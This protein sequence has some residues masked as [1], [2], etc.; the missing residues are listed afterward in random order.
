MSSLLRSYSQPKSEYKYLLS[1]ASGT[2]FTPD[3]LST[4]LQTA[5]KN[6]ILLKT[7]SVVNTTNGA[8]FLGTIA[9]RAFSAGTELIDMGKVLVIQTNGVVTYMFRLVQDVNGPLSGG[10]PSNYPTNKFYI[11]TFSSDLVVKNVVVSRSG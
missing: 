1:L 8:T 2:G 10:I 5:D 7:D 4:A 11:C 6:T 9:T 3:A